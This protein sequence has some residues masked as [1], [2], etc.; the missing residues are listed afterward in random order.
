MVYS[1]LYRVSRQ[2]CDSGLS[3]FS[4]LGVEVLGWLCV[5]S[6]GIGLWEIAITR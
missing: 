1:L 5:V 4:V 2:T 6:W 3:G